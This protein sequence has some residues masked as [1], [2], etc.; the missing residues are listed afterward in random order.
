MKRKVRRKGEVRK[1]DMDQDMMTRLVAMT[2]THCPRKHLS[3][4]DRAQYII[5]V[6]LNLMQL[7]VITCSVV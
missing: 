1:E 6:H 5:I 3:Y 2:R 7:L 4:L